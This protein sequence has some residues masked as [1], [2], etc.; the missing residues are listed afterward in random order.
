MWVGYCGHFGTSRYSEA[1]L[2]RVWVCFIELGYMD[3]WALTS[4]FDRLYKCI[5]VEYKYGYY[6]HFDTKIRS[7]AT[8]VLDISS[9]VNKKKIMTHA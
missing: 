2:F 8:M 5:E 9:Q 7:V 3:L 6:R 1:P 4:Y